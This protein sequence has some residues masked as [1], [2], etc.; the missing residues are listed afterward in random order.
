MGIQAKYKSP[1]HFAFQFS[2]SCL[3][4][5][6][7]EKSIMK[8]AETHATTFIKTLEKV[9]NVL[10]QK[11]LHLGQISSGEWYSGG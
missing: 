8:T 10:A 4:E 7:K 1:S 9:D 3:A 6:G 5:L 11:I 2:V